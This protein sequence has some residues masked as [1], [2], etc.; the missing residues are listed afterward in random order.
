M[1]K[2]DALLA[3]TKSFIAAIQ[4]NRSVEVSGRDGLRALGLAEKII[5]N[6]LSRLP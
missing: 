5:A 6:A 2:G 1:E 3:E 4:E